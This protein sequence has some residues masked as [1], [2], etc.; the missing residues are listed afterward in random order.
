MLST[1][2]VGEGNIELLSI[3]LYGGDIEWREG[4]IELFSTPPV[5]EG[6][7]ELLSTPAVIELLSI[8][9]LGRASL[10]RWAPSCW[11]GHSR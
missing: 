11:G 7:V 10:L 9:L 3:F 5:G 6:N 8:L 2:P 1:P 4:N